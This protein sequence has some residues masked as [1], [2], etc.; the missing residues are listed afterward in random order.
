MQKRVHI[1]SAVNA[2]NVSKSGSTYT[3][4]E[5]CGA[6]DGI[7]MHNML[8]EGAELAAGVGTLN[9]KPAPAGH[10][11]NAAGQF[12]SALSGDALLNAYCGAVCRTRAVARW[13]T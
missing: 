5:V 3:I 4:R 6:V 2:G 11:K 10:P 12:V 13:S 1:L 8:Y 9:D 7:V